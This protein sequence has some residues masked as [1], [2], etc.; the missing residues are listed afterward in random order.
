MKI[1]IKSGEELNKLLDA[2][3]KDIVDA[4]I[5]Y[6]LFAGLTSSI[7]NYSDEINQSNTFWFLT[8]QAIKEAFLFRL[9]RIFE[10]NDRSLNL[11]N[12][13]DTIKANRHYFEEPQFRE[14]LKDNAFIESLVE[15]VKIPSIEELQSDI[16]FASD[17][18]P[19]VKKL[20]LWRMNVYAHTGAKTALGKFVDSLEKNS[21]AKEEIEQLLDKCFSIS[22]KYMNL[23][24]SSTWSRQIIGHDDYLSL[25]KF[26]R[27]GLEKHDADIQ[28]ELAAWSGEK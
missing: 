26:L 4:N 5:Y 14:R 12:L 25:F 17:G 3:A 8:V 15:G 24:K 13:L 22:N 27:A 11:V 28:R 19:I 1:T 16:A 10:Q 20:I 23:Y 6:K 7:S 2:L 21:I 18:N 9:C